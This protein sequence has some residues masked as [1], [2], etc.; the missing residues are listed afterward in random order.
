LL[1]FLDYSWGVLK[2]GD[3]MKL[4]IFLTRVVLVPVV[5]FFVVS[6]GYAEDGITTAPTG[7]VESATNMAP[8]VIP[9]SMVVANMV[10]NNPPGE[11]DLG[12]LED[13]LNNIPVPP[14]DPNDALGDP[15]D[16]IPGDPGFDIDFGEI[17]EQAV[18]DALDDGTPIS[19]PGPEILPDAAPAPVGTTP[20]PPKPG[21]IPPPPAPGNVPPPPPVEPPPINVTSVPVVPPLAAVIVASSFLAVDGEGNPLG[22]GPIGTEA[23]EDGA[24]D[25]IEALGD[26]NDSLGDPGDLIP[27]DEGFYPVEEN[28]P[29]DP[30]D[31]LDPEPINEEDL[32]LV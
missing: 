5:S 25:I 27:G 1:I 22:P 7:P 18:I 31:S 24:I 20:A 12:I 14:A 32:P 21:P 10:M 11:L 3:P 28:C 9:Q 8:T 17:I 16:L 26:P 6:S 15:G 19:E 30:D 23:E 2:R 29:A 4:S 13:V